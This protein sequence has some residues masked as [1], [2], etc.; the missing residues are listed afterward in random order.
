MTGS[1]G[2]MGPM[3]TNLW[4]SILVVPLLA[5]CGGPRM[6][7]K[8]VTKRTYVAEGTCAQDL[9]RTSFISTGGRYGESITVTACGVRALA[10]TIEV[11]AETRKIGRLAMSGSFGRHSDNRRCLAGAA[12]VTEAGRNTSTERA[13]DEPTGRRGRALARSAPGQTAQKVTSFKEVDWPAE[14]CPNTSSTTI[15]LG[16]LRKDTEIRVHVWS[17]LP[18]DIS[19]AMLRITHNADKPNVSDE[20]WARHVK[21][22]NA[23]WAAEDKKAAARERIS[24]KERPRW[25]PRT[26]EV[27]PQPSAP[28]PPARVDA[29]PPQPSVHAEW[30][31]GYWHWSSPDWLWIAGRWR[32]P[33]TD[34]TRGLTVAAPYDP[35]PPRRESL[36]P[37]PI[38]GAVWSAGFWQW[39]G[40]AFVWVPGTWRIAPSAGARWQVP[41]WRPHRRGVIFVPGRW[42]RRR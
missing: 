29:R 26:I 11:S 13:A 12:V 9:A 32:V 8:P 41:H 34:V 24:R 27:K 20:E 19:G 28:P 1:N 42:V 21:E 16:E 35:P 37:Q 7:H 17:K 38:P 33:D 14:V 31:P 5:A 25:R 40:A 30:L 2:A 10:G 15:Q 18:N 3:F 6:L 22:R 36:P 23:R 39:S 4:L